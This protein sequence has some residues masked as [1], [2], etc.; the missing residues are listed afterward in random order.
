M[1][2]DVPEILTKFIEFHDD[3]DMVSKFY[4]LLRMTTLSISYADGLPAFSCRN[5]EYDKS[6]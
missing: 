5:V 3:P 4:A 1:A 2:V 6:S